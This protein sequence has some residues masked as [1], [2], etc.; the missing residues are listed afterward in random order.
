MEVPGYRFP[1]RGGW[2]G[3]TGPPSGHGSLNFRIY[4]RTGLLNL[5]RRIFL[6]FATHM[7]PMM[8]LFGLSTGVFGAILGP[9]FQKT[10]RAPAAIRNLTS[11][12]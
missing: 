3:A 11:G 4:P 5:L 1:P 10:Q 9:G 6:S 12:V 8:T 7:W 2:G